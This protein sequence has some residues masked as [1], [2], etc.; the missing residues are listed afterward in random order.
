MKRAAAVALLASGCAFLS[1]NEPLQPRYFTVEPEPKAAAATA[2]SDL[3][4]R[5]GPVVAGSDIRQYLTIRSSDRELG[6]SADLRWTERPESYLRRALS[7]A[8]FE[9]RGVQRV[10]SGVAPTLDVEL[11]AFE[12]VRQAP[13]RVR[14]AAV[15]T[16]HDGRLVLL[17]KTFAQERPLGAVK[18]AERPAAV[19]RELGAAMAAMVE[20]IAGEVVKR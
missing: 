11:V 20:E 2:R 12:E 19:A 18:E 7:R 1:K 17:E 3:K 16:L 6:Y 10:L 5:L 14:V 8:F 13:A 9:E 4:L 15:I